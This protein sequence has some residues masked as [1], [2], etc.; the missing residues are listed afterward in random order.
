MFQFYHLNSRHWPAEG[1]KEP[2]AGKYEADFLG[3]R[4]TFQH[5]GREVR[6]ALYRQPER[7]RDVNL[8]AAPGVVNGFWN[9]LSIAEELCFG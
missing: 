1:P 8:P 7:P 2:E 3:P 6:P 9:R 5:P 4:P